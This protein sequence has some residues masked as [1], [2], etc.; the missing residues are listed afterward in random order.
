MDYGREL[1]FLQETMQKCRLQTIVTSREE[2]KIGR[3]AGRNIR[4]EE[5]FLR[6]VRD[7]LEQ[8]D[9]GT[10]Y[11]YT[12]R[13]FCSYLCLALDEEQVLFIG[14]YLTVD[15]GREQLLKIAEELRVPADQLRTLEQHY[16]AIPH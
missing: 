15:V 16:Q 12:D 2:L 3:V 13:Y 14:P 6:L 8:L 11:K 5:H 4:A 9:L 7:R 10:L 1:R